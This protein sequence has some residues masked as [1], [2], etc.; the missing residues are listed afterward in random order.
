[1]AADEKPVAVAALDVEPRMRSNYPP[2]FAERVA[3]RV[4]RPLGD[5]FGLANFGVNLTTLKPGA[6]SALRHSHLKQDE[7]IYALS[8]TAVLVTNRGET[9]LKPEI[10]RAHV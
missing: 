2:P 9:V 7:L 1:M 3:G 5:V 6:I 8:G 4:K 10:G